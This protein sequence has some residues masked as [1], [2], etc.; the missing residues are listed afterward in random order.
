MDDARRT[1]TEQALQ[2]QLRPG[3][4]GDRAGLLS[5]V[6]ACL[7]E[8]VARMGQP[9]Q[10]GQGEQARGQRVFG[11]LKLVGGQPQQFQPLAVR[12]ARRQLAQAVAGQHQ[13]L[14]PGAVAQ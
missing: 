12:D 3:D 13:L 9:G 11:T 7:A 10:P 14:Q 8:R 6:L 5:S 4:R 2:C 1:F